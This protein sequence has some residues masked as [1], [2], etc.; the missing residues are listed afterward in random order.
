ML[1]VSAQPRAREGKD[2]LG[3]PAMDSSNYCL[4]TAYTQPGNRHHLMVVS[5]LQD[6]IQKGAFRDR[7]LQ[8]Y[9]LAST[10]LKTAVN[11]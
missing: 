1:V 3:H 7:T 10:C 9:M 8:I 4:P 5:K 11:N 6:C 2:L